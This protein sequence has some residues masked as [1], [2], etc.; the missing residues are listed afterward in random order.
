MDFA[1]EQT[2]KYCVNTLEDQGR[3]Y[4]VMKNWRK[5]RSFV[6]QAKKRLFFPEMFLVDE[7]VPL[8]FLSKYKSVKMYQCWFYEK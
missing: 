1:G 7:E 3:I 4:L 2:K 8:Y 6:M 5:E